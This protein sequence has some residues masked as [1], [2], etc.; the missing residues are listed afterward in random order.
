MKN[1]F[2]NLKV[3]AL[4]LS[5]ACALA[6]SA[7]VTIWVYYDDDHTVFG[8]DGIGDAYVYAYANQ[9]DQHGINNVDWPGTLLT[10]HAKIETKNWYWHTITGINS[11]H[12]IF[13]NGNGSEAPS[14]TAKEGDNYYYYTGSLYAINLTPMKEAVDAGK[15][16]F[17]FEEPTWWRT[18]NAYTDNDPYFYAW[19]G[20]TNNGDWPGPIMQWIGGKKSDVNHNVYGAYTDFTPENMI[21]TRQWW[22]N[23][24]PKR[25]EYKVGSEGAGLSILNRGYYEFGVISDNKDENDYIM[26]VYNYYTDITFPKMV[27]A[28]L[29]EI[30]ANPRT[31]VVYTISDELTVANR[32]NDVVYAK[33]NNGAAAQTA[34]SDEIDYNADIF[35]YSYDYSNWIALTGTDPSTVGEGFKLTGV[36]GVL[37]DATN[38]TLAV[39]DATRSGTG[40]YD[41]NNYTPC[42]FYG[43]QVSSRNGKTYFFAHPQVMEFARINYAVY[44]DNNIFEIPEKKGDVNYAN[45]H[46]SF[47]ADLNGYGSSFTKGN[48]YNFDAVIKAAA[49]GNGAPRRVVSNGGYTVM[50]T[51]NVEMPD[52]TTGV[53]EVSAAAQVAGVQYVD[54]AG[55]VSDRPFH[56][57][58]IVVTTMTDGS[59]RTTKVMK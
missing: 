13:N 27:T 17:I 32:I 39:T 46:G 55:R 25:Y 10:H 26:H 19:L 57:M 1:L 16:Y 9:G 8:N 44:K 21:F 36:T 11:C 58:N 28:T 20:S 42:N 37:T 5:A 38:F 31:D 45:L 12:V 23:N 47:T 30:E 59:T 35:H 18:Q 48:T 52:I 51:G 49:S 50:V 33:D 4:T 3:W 22:E 41:K 40:T 6:A 15:P 24:E 34:G 53:S 43:T 54:M 56:G 14:L 29:A 2:C 7:D